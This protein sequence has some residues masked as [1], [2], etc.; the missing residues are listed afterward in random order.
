MPQR[1]S[2]SQ[3]PEAGESASRET[4]G[5]REGLVSSPR[6]GA[7][8]TIRT[9][10]SI[11]RVD[12]PVAAPHIELP[13]G[14]A[15]ADVAISQDVL[16]QF[17]FEHGGYFDSYLATEPGRQRFWSQGRQ[18]LISYVMRGR[19]VLVGGGLIAPDDHKADLLAEFVE[20]TDRRRLK[21]AFHNIGDEDLPVFR[22]FGFQVT[23]WGEEPVIDLGA[24]TWSGKAYEW[25]R[26]QSNYCQRHGLTAFEVR[27]EELT[28]EQWSRTLTEVLEV[29][30]ECLSLKPQAD[31]MRFFEGRID[32][33]ELGRRR[34][35]LA[36]SAHGAGRLE[37]FVVCN[38]MRGGT[39]W[40]T[41]MYR[42]RANSVRGTMAFLIQHLINQLQSEGAGRVG[43][44]LDP[45]LRC[46]PLPGDSFLV[47]RG[48]QF[49]E[50]W[51]G[52]V[53]DVAGLR[54]FKSRFR[55]RY[56]N[57]YVCA[58]PKI[59]PGSVWA[60][61]Q[62][63]GAFNLSLPKLTR[64]VLERIRKRVQRQTLATAE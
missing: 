22:R 54:H 10:D 55:P 3:P 39:I 12:Q 48:M 62:V 52:L 43:M 28:P 38:P 53:F 61:T 37:G 44:C 21:V 9:A 11:L 64:I 8:V 49:T 17:A 31:E 47:R 30:A 5:S 2:R 1:V 40:A 57:R 27:P 15:D 23:K 33:H 7:G 63:F 14:A 46:E 18:G 24:C 6:P 13:A 56:E 60:F 4:N 16:E 29:A 26:R 51:L 19:Y 36:R 59:S 20:H 34:L 32:I 42:H 35:F 41:E 58:R 25:V 50:N 45:G